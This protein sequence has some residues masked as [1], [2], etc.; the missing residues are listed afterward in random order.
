V[1]PL[2]RNRETIIEGRLLTTSYGTG[3]VAINPDFE[4]EYVIPWG[5]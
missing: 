4:N 5:D 3:G 2:K 1:V